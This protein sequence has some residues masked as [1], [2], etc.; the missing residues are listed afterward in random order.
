MNTRSAPHGR[1]ARRACAIVAG[2]ALGW[3]ATTDV[4]RA[5]QSTSGTGGIPRSTS[6]NLDFTI[7]I[8]KFI[9]F[10][11]GD[12][13]WP[14]QSG[15]VNTVAFALSTSIPGNGAPTAGNNRATSWN[16][17]APIFSVSATGNVLPVE[18]RSN[19]GQ[20]TLRATT[21]GPLTNTG[22]NTIP[23]S[24]ITVASSDSALPAPTIPATGLGPTVNVSSGGP[25]IGFTQVT[26]RAAD[27]TFSYANTANRPAG[28][29]T[30][31]ITFTASSP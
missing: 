26:Q 11:V 1:I 25:G 22:G 30:G 6:V 4:A 7:S 19:A 15:T 16:G 29:Y 23:M 10:R 17:T 24:E 20:V 2:C 21:T 8:D 12:G 18:V 28:T 13:A 9:F 14:V 27:W 31:Q 3:V 5:A